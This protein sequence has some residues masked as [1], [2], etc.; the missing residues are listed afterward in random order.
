M[1]LKPRFVYHIKDEY[2]HLA[3]DSKLMRNHEGGA[4]RPTYYCLLDEKTGLSWVVPMSRRVEKY[5]AIVQRDI[6]KRGRCIKIVIGD[7][8]GRNVVFLLQNMFPILP[9]YIDHIHTVKQKEIPVNERLAKQI[10]QNFRE[11]RRLH[12]RGAKVVFPDIDRLE[13]LMLAC[14]QKDQQI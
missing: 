13:Q 2:F 1:Q 4:C 12:A 9:E 7:F 3:N 8:A 14:R 5:Q 10:D 6:D 11:V